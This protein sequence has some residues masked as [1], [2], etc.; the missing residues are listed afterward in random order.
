MLVR[1]DFQSD[2]SGVVAWHKFWL[3]VRS[4]LKN[5]TPQ[6]WQRPSSGTIEK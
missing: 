4:G 5:L 1:H 2:V 3:Q 6:S